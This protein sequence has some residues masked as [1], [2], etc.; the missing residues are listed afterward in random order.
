MKMFLSLLITIQMASGKDKSHDAQLH[1]DDHM[2]L[3]KSMS[4]LCRQFSLRVTPELIN[5]SL[6]ADIQKVVVSELL[7]QNFEP[8]GLKTPL[9]V[10]VSLLV[11]CFLLNRELEEVRGQLKEVKG[12]QKEIKGQSNE[13][14]A[15]QEDLQVLKEHYDGVSCVLIGRMYC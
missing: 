14:K 15:L 10:I 2:T 3:R 12:H 11:H 1:D 4:S 8:H 9:S 7:P 13:V 6:Q 5:T